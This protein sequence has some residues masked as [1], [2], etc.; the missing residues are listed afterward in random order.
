VAAADEAPTDEVVA[1]V[2]LGSPPT[3]DCKALS[4][5][6]RVE[7]PP[8]ADAPPACALSS[9]V[10]VLLA[11]CEEGVSFETADGADGVVSAVPAAPPSKS[12]SRLEAS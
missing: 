12:C 6:D 2:E 5:W 11:S 7:V 4:N 9:D 1:A 8:L 10:K 3:A